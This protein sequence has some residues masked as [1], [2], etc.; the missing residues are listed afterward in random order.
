M[1]PYGGEIGGERHRPHS[2]SR[3][4]DLAPC[5]VDLCGEAPHI[6]EEDLEEDGVDG[7]SIVSASEDREHPARD[8]TAGLLTTPEPRRR[9]CCGRL[10]QPGVTEV[11]GPWLAR[12]LRVGHG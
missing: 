2:R 12:S 11:T 1:D 7:R 4:W 8:V 3:V 9:V 10:L 5:V 6:G